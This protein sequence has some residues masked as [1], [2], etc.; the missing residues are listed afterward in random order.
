VFGG[1]G[2]RRISCFQ[3]PPACT[4]RALISLFWHHY[5]PLQASLTGRGPTVAPHELFAVHVSQLVALAE[6]SAEDGRAD[7]GWHL[8]GGGGG[9]DGEYSEGVGEGTGEFARLAAAME[10]RKAAVAAL[11]C[12]ATKP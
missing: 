8:G 10:G 6:S 9:E 1:D 2:R 4:P 5:C 3:C 11:L 7:D 12:E